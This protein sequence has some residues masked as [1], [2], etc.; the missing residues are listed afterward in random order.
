MQILNL[1]K[2]R[3]T[4]NLTQINLSKILNVDNSTISGWETGKDT[5]PLEKLINY[6]N[7]FNYNLDYLFGISK[8]NNF[9]TPYTVNLDSIGKKLKILRKKNKL[10][11]EEVSNK[12]NTSKS[13]FWAYEN[14]KILINTSFLFG[15]T[16]IFKNFS[17]D[18]LFSNNS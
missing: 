4:L 9:N 12:L 14:G 17:I 11:I 16:N 6:A 18:D 3:E 15:L 13:T 2:S 1:R 5:I 7:K 8:N 10:T